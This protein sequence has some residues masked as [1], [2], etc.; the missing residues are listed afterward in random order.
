VTI[1]SSDKTTER[2]LLGLVS[3]LILIGILVAGLWPF[4]APSNQVTWLNS[5]NGVRLGPHGT[6]LAAR[7]LT[8]S[9]SLE[10]GPC[11]LEI[12]LKPNR[13]EDS[14]TILAFFT[15]EHTIRFSL[16]HSSAN[17]ALQKGPYNQ[18]IPATGERPV[19][20]NDVFRKIQ[21]LLITIT[22]GEQGTTIYI[23]GKL[24]RTAS[25]LRMSAA[26]FSGRLVL[27]TSPVVD[28]NWSGELRGL[29]IY[30]QQLTAIQVFHHFETWTTKGRLIDLDERVMALYPFDEHVG[31]TVHDRGGSGIDL[32]IP[33]QYV[34]AHEKVLEPPWKEFYPQW[35]Y[36]KNVLI[37][38][39]GF[40]PL[41]F[42]FCAYLS[43]APTITRPALATIIL[44]AALSITI[45]ALQGYLP[46]RNS[47]MTD[48]IT[49][50][51]GT[52]FGVMLYRWKGFLLLETLQR[53]RAAAL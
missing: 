5:I 14:G 38:I 36:W 16:H 46:T 29:A 37:N 18:H 7:S 35:G 44:G 24:A 42:F 2:K 15:R 10:R 25:W 6:V 8:N 51:I 20:V 31:R 45:E 40:I 52:G 49:N 11:S 1:D 26:D 13:A 4:H 47:G 48:I 21:P 41:G 3:I 19:Y 53:I 50:T 33:E 28:D 27:G 9:G 32:Y 34:I 23:D 12:C 39:G 17:L 43:T 30:N 22:S